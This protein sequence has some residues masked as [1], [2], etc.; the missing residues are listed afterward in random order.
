MNEFLSAVADLLA[1][2]LEMPPDEIAALIE[3]PR[4]ISHGD[5]ALPC[6]TL[7]KKLRMAPQKIAAGL[8]ARLEPAPPIERVVPTG[9]YLNFFIDRPQYIGSILAGAISR[10]DAFGSSDIGAGKTICLDMSSP[11][12][13]KHL[14]VYHLLSTMIGNALYHIFSALGYRVVRINHL[15]DWGT[16]FGKLIVA[17]KRYGNGDP[18]EEDAIDKLNA[19]YVRFHDDAE[20]HPELDDEARAWFKKMEDGDSEALRMWQW[21]KDLSLHEFEEAY[22]MLGVGFDVFTGEA[23]YNDKMAPVIGQAEAKGITEVSEGALVVRLGE[24]IPPCMLRRSD[25]ATLYATRD[26]TAAIDRKDR[27]SF[28][29][30]VYVVD[31]RQS[32]HFRQVFGVLERMGFAWAG[33]C[34]H[35]PFGVMR[36]G[37]KLGATRKGNVVLLND[38]LELAIARA[39][40]IIDEKNPALPDKEAIASSVGIGAAVFGVLRSGRVNDIDFSIEEAV[41][42]DG[43]TG[44]YLQYTHARLCSIIRKYG[45]PVPA[46]I[47]PARLGTDEDIQIAQMLE[48][49]GP[50]VQ[51]AADS[52]EPSIV[53]NY[54]LDLAALYN[55][56]NNLHRVLNPGD[57]G[58]TDA[59]V[60][61]VAAVRQTLSNG[62]SMLGIEALEAM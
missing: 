62:L 50:T 30:N 49:F 36:F 11:N 4:E 48:Q 33:D 55:R 13:A 40:E 56:H 24:D 54:L 22:R 37:G 16:Q 61:L 32:L 35:V 51:R 7:A 43:R 27:F 29:K 52:Y 42:F 8:A 9:P 59:R 21:F 41:N 44:P 19:M 2:A 12:I 39:R 25:D 10:G 60:R 47:D 14:A 28:H 6:F 34:V 58:L 31:G 26:I 23:Y 45:K 20:L 57:A 17:Y 18:L 5:F 53:G 1:P 38:V 15:G 3:R 46:R